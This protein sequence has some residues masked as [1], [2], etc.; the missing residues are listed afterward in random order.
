MAAAILV[1]ALTHPV[2]YLVEGRAEVVEYNCVA[3]R[4]HQMILWRWHGGLPSPQWH[5]SEWVYCDP[6]SIQTTPRGNHIR[7]QWRG[8]KGRCFDVICH[9]FRETETGYDRE[10][11]DRKSLPLNRRVPQ[12]R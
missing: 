12:L 7:V 11:H 5:V 9:T 6:D 4:F 8:D 2:P 3:D 10:V 1:L